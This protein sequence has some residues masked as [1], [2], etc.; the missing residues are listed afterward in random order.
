MMFTEKPLV[1]VIEVL[2][3][4]GYTRDYN[5]IED[6]LADSLDGS[7]IEIANLVIDKI[8]RFTGLNDLDD[9]TILYAISNLDD[10]TKGIFVNGYGTYSDPKAYEVIKQITIND[11]NNEEWISA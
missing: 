10:D 5:L 1:E 4:R 6:K 11:S 3:A 8:Y 2:R 7:C 9:E